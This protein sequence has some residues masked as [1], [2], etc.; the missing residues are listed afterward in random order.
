MLQQTQTALNTSLVIAKHYIDQ[1]STA[2]RQYTDQKLEQ[3]LQTTDLAAK[4]ALLEEINNIL[5]GDNATAGFQAW[6]AEVAKLAQ[7]R[8]ELDVAK[9]DIATHTQQIALINASL[10]NLSNTLGQRITDEVAALNATIIAKDAATNTR[11]DNVQ[12]QVEA[13]KTAQ[14]AK[15]VAQSAKIAANEAAIGSVTTALQEEAAARIAADQLFNTRVTTNEAD[16]AQLKAGTGD[17]VTKTQVVAAM[18]QMV[19]AAMN[20]FG[21][22]ANGNPVVNAGNGAVI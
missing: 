2:N 17:F 10:T 15:D 19:I 12:A 16:I 7:L 3:V 1:S 13:D 20:V 5:D 9:G 14:I 11:I 21:L 6:Q 4:L 22:D 8:A 18:S